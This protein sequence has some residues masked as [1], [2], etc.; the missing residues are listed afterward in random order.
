MDNERCSLA[1]GGDGD[2][3]LQVSSEAIVAYILGC[4][5]FEAA[6]RFQLWCCQNKSALHV[7][8]HDP[9][10]EHKV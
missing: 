3:L 8:W 7:F 1:K 9:V 6:S 10:D 2:I 4:V 5:A